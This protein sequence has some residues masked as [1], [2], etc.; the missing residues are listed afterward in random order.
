[1]PHGIGK[2]AIS[3]SIGDLKS[4]KF[5]HTTPQIETSIEEILKLF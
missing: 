4:K 2:L 5:R 1:M 3:C